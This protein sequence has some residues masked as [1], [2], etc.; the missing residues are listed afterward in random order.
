MIKNLATMLEEHKGADYDIYYKG[1]CI[2]SLMNENRIK[3]E[4]LFDDNNL[5]IKDTVKDSL[6]C[7]IN[8]DNCINIDSNITDKYIEQYLTMDICYG[9]VK[10][11]LA[12][13]FHLA[14]TTIVI[15]IRCYI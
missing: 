2:D 1:D 15:R 6:V 9:K 10:K 5:Y 11:V 12:R 7:K 4:Y 14:N 13:L 3:L 8:M